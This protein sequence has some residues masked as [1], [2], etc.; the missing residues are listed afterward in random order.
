MI[1]VVY[2]HPNP[3]SLN[4]EIKERVC[5][6]LTEQKKRFFVVDLYKEKFNPA[7]SL[8]ELIPPKD[9]KKHKD[10]LVEKY[11]NQVMQSDKLIFIYPTWWSAMPAI[12][13]GYFDKV[14][15]ARF[16]FKYVKVPFLNFGRPVGLLKGKKALV[17][18]TI[19]APV[20]LEKLILGNRTIKIICN[21]ILK[22]CAI[23][24]YYIQIEKAV[25]GNEK[26]IEKQLTKLE[27]K[28][29]RFLKK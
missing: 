14:Y 16:A 22:F 25:P 28:V 15:S 27:Y 13:K 8:N 23:K 21:D 3:K 6:I 2:A 20:L 10:P 12:L 17:I 18:T 5:A 11:Q 19:G 26:A 4:H 29:T 9:E 24:P 7:M 1:T